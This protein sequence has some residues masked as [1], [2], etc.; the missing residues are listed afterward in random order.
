[1]QFVHSRTSLSVEMPEKRVFKPKS[2][3]VVVQIIQQMKF[4][5][6]IT[7]QQPG[8][9]VSK[10]MSRSPSLNEVITPGPLVS[11]SPSQITGLS[12]SPASRL[13]HTKKDK[14]ISAHPMIDPW[15]I[16]NFIAHLRCMT[17]KTWSVFWKLM[18]VYELVYHVSVLAV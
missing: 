10:N 14:H 17:S 11:F 18:T 8:S 12:A 4:S 7:L 13:G 1:M 9:H 5:Y 15:A 3:T 16:R 6:Q 2:S